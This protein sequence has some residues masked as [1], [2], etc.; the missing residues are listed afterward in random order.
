MLSDLMLSRANYPNL[1]SNDIPLPL[2]V[3]NKLDKS[4][5]S[6]PFRQQDRFKSVKSEVR[7]SR[8]SDSKLQPDSTWQPTLIDYIS[9]N[10]QVLSDKRSVNTRL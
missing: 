9:L 2:K 3:K 6:I 10:D 1:K 5:I 4:F 7:K 8:D